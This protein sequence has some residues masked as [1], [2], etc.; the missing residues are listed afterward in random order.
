M[1]AWLGKFQRG[2]KTSI[3]DVHVIFFIIIKKRDFWST[4][5]KESK[6]ISR[7]PEH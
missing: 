1:E 5:A 4:G 6:W 7:K 2:A 3:R